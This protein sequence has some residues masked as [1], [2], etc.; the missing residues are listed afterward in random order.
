MLRRIAGHLFWAARYLERAQWRARL[1][2]VNYALVLEVP[3]RDAEPWEPLLAITAETEKFG[4]SHSV[5]DEAR[6]VGFFTFD[7]ENPSSIRNC[8]ESARTNL[9]SLRHLISSELWLEINKLY[10][11][12][13]SWSADALAIAGMSAFFGELRDRFHA[14]TGIISSTMPRDAAYY[15][16]E[17][18]TMIERADNVSRM[19]DVKYHYLLPRFEDVGGPSDL[20]QWAAVLRSASALEAFRKTY[21][22]AMRVDRVVE[23]LVLNPRF[24]RSVRF[25]LDRIAVALKEIELCEMA[26]P[27]HEPAY[28]GPLAPMLAG[29]AAD[30]IASGLHE[31]LISVERECSGISD[32]I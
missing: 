6:V 9:A 14:I 4:M 31:F 11:D 26:R 13:K 15:F 20:R 21:G 23:M 27:P 24:P 18:G 22:N 10:L 17:L 30:V 32:R 7:K 1:I 5:A 8:V 28:D 12:A 25:C 3:P 16:M 19:L 2:D 29:A